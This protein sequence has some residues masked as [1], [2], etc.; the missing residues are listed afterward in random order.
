MLTRIEGSRIRKW[1]KSDLTSRRPH[2]NVSA[3]AL[4]AKTPAK[5][6]NNIF[7]SA[8]VFR[9]VCW[10][11]LCHCYAFIMKSL[12]DCVSTR[13]LSLLHCQEHLSP[14]RCFT[15]SH[16][17]V[18]Q[19]SLKDSL[20]LNSLICCI[21]LVNSTVKKKKKMWCC[22]LVVNLWAIV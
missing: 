8:S 20:G 2:G 13:P 22:L 1:R 3:L 12:N 17:S 16:V 6:K 18:K 5:N 21:A 9:A 14:F 15:F 19:P 10:K 7:E 4:T 11:G